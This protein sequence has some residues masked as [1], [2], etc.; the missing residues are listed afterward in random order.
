MKTQEELYAIK[1]ELEA[2]NQKLSE[3]N[4]D[5]LK[6]IAAGLSGEYSI[7]IPDNNPHYWESWNPNFLYELRQHLNNKDN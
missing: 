1:K 4:E 3:L 2:V 6:E 7:P 5:E